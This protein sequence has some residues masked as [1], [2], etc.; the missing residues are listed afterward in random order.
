[1]VC[2]GRS[3]TTTKSDGVDLNRDFAAA[4]GWKKNTHEEYL[5]SYMA[6]FNYLQK[7]Q[8]YRVLCPKKM[9]FLAILPYNILLCNALLSLRLLFRML[10]ITKQCLLWN[11]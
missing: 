4:I 10:E 5:K 2:A 6:V 7:N 1:M 9:L 8:S 11:K 3:R